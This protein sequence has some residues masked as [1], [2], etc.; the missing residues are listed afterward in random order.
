MV[1]TYADA[2]PARSGAVC[3]RTPPAQR[4]GFI[5]QTVVTYERAAPTPPKRP[6]ARRKT[7]GDRP[8][9]A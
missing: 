9:S 3:L 7:A 1:E 5:E 6:Q 8:P 4:E 2:P